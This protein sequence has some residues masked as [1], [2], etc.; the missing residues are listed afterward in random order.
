M[1]QVSNN[2][3]EYDK[4]SDNE[5]DDDEGGSEEDISN[6]SE[7]EKYVNRRI[8]EVE[9]K[10]S[11]KKIIISRNVNERYSS[12]SDV[13]SLQRYSIQI[14]SKVKYRDV[15]SFNFNHFV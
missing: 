3:F 13:E 14:V 4:E 7:Y 9:R 8:K 15:F 5:G 1:A 6:G 10:Q 12:K 11:D 2:K